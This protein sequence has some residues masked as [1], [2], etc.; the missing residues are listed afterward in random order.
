MRPVLL[1]SLTLSLLFGLGPLTACRP[2]PKPTPADSLPTA[3]DSVQIPDSAGVPM[4]PADTGSMETS[5]LL[6]RSTLGA[7]T[8]TA[9]VYQG[10]AFG[11]A[12]LMAGTSFEFGPAPFTGTLE[13][14]SPSSVA[15]QV[16]K[17]RASGVRLILNLTSGPHSDYLSGGKFDHAKWLTRLRLY[18]TT[19]ARA[20]IAQGIADGTVLGFLMV[21]EPEHISWGGVFDKPLLDQMDQ[22]SKALFPTLPTGIQHGPGAYKWM[23]DQ[24]FHSMD[25]VLYA[26]KW[27]VQIRNKY[28]PGDVNGW[29]G[30][31]LAQNA[32]DGT[33]AVF[34]L[35]HLDGGVQDKTGAWDCPWTAKGTYAPN[36]VMSPQQVREYGSA[37]IPFAAY[38]GS[39]RYDWAWFRS[40]A[41]IDAYRSLAPLAASQ[42]LRTLRRP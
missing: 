37:L 17:A 24:Q 6:Q 27:N 35:N 23:K 3:G 19:S 29:L 34:S 41:N 28:G 18:N 20:A 16:A 33:T 22:E 8:R 32:L 38:F 7:F 30:Q 31:V 13:G 5:S 26:Y 36:C 2:K 1:L 42:P 25:W 15:S 11:P 9:A 12:Q 21:D 4:D 14:V 39:W 10:I 40:S